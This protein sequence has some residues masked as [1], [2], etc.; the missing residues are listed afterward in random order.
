MQMSY[1]NCNP[2][3]AQTLKNKAVDKEALLEYVYNAQS[4]RIDKMNIRW[5]IRLLQ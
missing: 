4:I 1:H 3:V 5:N 2:M